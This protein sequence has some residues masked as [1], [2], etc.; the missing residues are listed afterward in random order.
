MRVEQ[1][2]VADAGKGA[3]FGVLGGLVRRTGF[4]RALQVQMQQTCRMMDC[5][6]VDLLA[7]QPI[8]Q[9]GHPRS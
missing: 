1:C 4:S 6:D 2:L 8:H 3:R 7:D 9:R 5:E